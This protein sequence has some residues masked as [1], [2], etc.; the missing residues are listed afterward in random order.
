MNKQR[1]RPLSSHW[2]FA[3][4]AVLAISLTGCQS[5]NNI[6]EDAGGLAAE[7]PSEADSPQKSYFDNESKTDHPSPAQVPDQKASTETSGA[8]QDGHPKEDH[9]TEPGKWDKSLPTLNGT[10]IGDSSDTVADRYGQEIDRYSLEDPAGTVTVLEY[11][12]FSVGMNKN[13][14][15]QFV[16]VYEPQIAAGL[17]GLRIGNKT[18]KAVDALGKPTSATDYLL[19]YDAEG[20]TL[21]L[22]VNP[23][24]NEIVSMKLLAN[25]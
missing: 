5:E 16:E 9:E 20:A 7:Q 13:H 4:L 11:E 15:V 24:S 8:Q 21:K 6:D 2:M 14:T 23:D 1:N 17:N 10:A 12:G 25:G 3:A 19:I 22:D 18:E